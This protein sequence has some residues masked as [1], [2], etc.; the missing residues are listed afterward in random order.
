MSNKLPISELIPGMITSAN[1]IDGKGRTVIAKNTRLTPIH[2]NGLSKWGVTFV[3]VIETNNNEEQHNHNIKIDF[4]GDEEKEFMR[5]VVAKVV[6]KF[7]NL[8]E[9]ELNK[10]LRRLTIKHLILNGRGVVPGLN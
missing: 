9:T 3:Y 10:E 8:P 5:K 4:K 1:I 2:I 6:D 7:K